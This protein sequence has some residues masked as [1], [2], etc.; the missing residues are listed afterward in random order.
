MTDTRFEQDA[1]L[2]VDPDRNGTSSS[3]RR[4]EDL[5]GLEAGPDRRRL[6]PARKQP[7]ST[8]RS[9]VEWTVVLG[10]ALVVALVIRTFLFAT[11]WIPSAS[12]EPTLMGHPGRND[13]VIV[14]KLSYR[15]HDVNRGDIVVFSKPT[16][17]AP[18][19]EN[20][21]EVKDLIKRVVGLENETIS[22]RDG[23]VLVD[24]KVL[25]E[26][27]LE[28]D[29]ETAPCGEAPEDLTIEIPDNSVLV[30][31]DNRKNSKDGRCFGP[32]KES[33]IVGRA[34]VRIWPITEFGGL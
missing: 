27:Y 31:G 32:I 17:E 15:V 5:L 30:M 9:I 4:L 33:S 20:G 13:R 21:S 29:A 28:D 22:F 16:T 10:G 34:F 26:P 25:P 6:V 19:E 1:G 24:G 12:M 18:I 8:L 3:R 11:F 2:A 14:N 7:P 23:R